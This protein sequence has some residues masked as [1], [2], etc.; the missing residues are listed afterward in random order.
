M[1]NAPVVQGNCS[2]PDAATALGLTVEEQASLLP[3]KPRQC[4]VIVPGTLLT[5][6]GGTVWLDNLYLM[7]QHTEPK[8]V[9]R[10]VLTDDEWFPGTGK[11]MGA[12]APELFVTN[13]TLHRQL[14][15]RVSGF[16]TNVKA[17]RLFLQGADS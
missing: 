9:S 6:E 8:T 4:V 15:G 16:M 13:A 14:R 1:L 17:S 3:L 2:N 12:D 11:G 10:F 5:I 7:L